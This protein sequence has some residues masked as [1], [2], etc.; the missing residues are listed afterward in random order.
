MKK[1]LT[2]SLAFLV[3][4]TASPTNRVIHAIWEVGGIVQHFIH[5]L[6]CEQ[7]PFGVWEFFQIHSPGHPHHDTNHHEHG[8][9]PFNCCHHYPT[10]PVGQQGPFVLHVNPYL[11]HSLHPE[12]D[13]HRLITRSETWRSTLYTGDIWQPPKV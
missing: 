10:S 8:E 1:F 5:H 9:L 11:L 7:E 3:L 13:A 12:N 2:L 6:T 4:A